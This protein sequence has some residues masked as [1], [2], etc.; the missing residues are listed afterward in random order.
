MSDFEK[1]SHWILIKLK[2]HVYNHN[3]KVFVL[4]DLMLSDW[5]SRLSVSRW[6]CLVK[7]VNAIA[8]IVNVVGQNGFD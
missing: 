6:F 5:I 1:F 3:Q 4:T 8:G 2:T 7:V